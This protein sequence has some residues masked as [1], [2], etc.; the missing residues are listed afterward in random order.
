M[1]NHRNSL[2]PLISYSEIQ[3]CEGT[4]ACSLTC[5]CQ[6]ELT[7]L[8]TDTCLTLSSQPA[9]HYWQ[10]HIDM[11]W[12]GQDWRAA[13]FT[14]SSVSLSLTWFSP[15]NSWNSWRYFSHTNAQVVSRV[16]KYM[17]TSC[18][19]FSLISTVAVFFF[20]TSDKGGFF[21]FYRI[22]YINLKEVWPK[23]TLYLKIWPELLKWY[24]IKHY[25][26]PNIFM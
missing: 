7:Y 12:T 18:F 23:N 22:F 11:R 1:L 14:V 26:P 4:S 6:G 5:V 19:G 10:K 17:W 20:I 24:K 25:R 9:V 13:A 2:C 21:Q 3:S 8:V 15:E 16:T